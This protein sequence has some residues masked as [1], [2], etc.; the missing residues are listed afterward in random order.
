MDLN[1]LFFRHQIALMR[2]AEANDGDDRA[3]HAAA[4]DDLA[5][6]IRDVQSRSGARPMPLM[7]AEAN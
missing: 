4:A 1:K 2:A 5:S 7:P 3:Q 6:C